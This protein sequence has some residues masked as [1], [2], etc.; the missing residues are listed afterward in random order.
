MT[1]EI[2]QIKFFLYE[3]WART[4]TGQ[5]TVIGQ[6]NAIWVTKTISFDRFIPGASAPPWYR[7]SSLDKED[8]GKKLLWH[9]NI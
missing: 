9:M 8:L 4:K 6:N 2:N 5:H 7:Y 1:D 3:N